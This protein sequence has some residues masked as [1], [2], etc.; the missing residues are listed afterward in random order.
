MPRSAEAFGQQALEFIEEVDRLGSPASVVE[1]V[2]RVIRTFGFDGLF[3]AEL[4]PRPIHKFDDFVLASRCPTEFGPIYTERNYAAV[5]ANIRRARRSTHTFEWSEAGYADDDGE[6]HTVEFLRFLSDF[7]FPR[8][9]VVPIHGPCGFVAGVALA[10][11]TFDL[12]AKT[13]P[14]LH[15]ITLYA[16]DRIHQLAAA[17]SEKNPPLTLREREVLAWSAQGKSAWEIGEILHLAKRTV[18][19]HAK[20]A[21]RKLGATTRTQAVAIAIRQRLFEA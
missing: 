21:M 6:P 11:R 1:A 2:Y 4:D 5:D 10:G 7:G 18:D 20:T 9:F 17:E 15:I 13:K 14:T 3:F 19:E 12:S 16:F 8:G